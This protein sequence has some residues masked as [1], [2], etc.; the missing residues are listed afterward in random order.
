[1][2]EKEREKIQRKGKAGGGGGGKRGEKGGKKKGGRKEIPG[3]RGGRTTGGPVVMATG[4][5]RGSRAD[6]RFRRSP[7]RL[8]AP[9]SGVETGTGVTNS[10]L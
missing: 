5:S 6:C 3:C 1:M 10:F 2:T 9:D 8:V 4:T 7:P